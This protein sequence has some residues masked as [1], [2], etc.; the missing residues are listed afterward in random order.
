MFAFHA[1]N[2]YPSVSRTFSRAAGMIVGTVA[3]GHVAT[4]AYDKL[5]KPIVDWQFPRSPR[6]T[7]APG[8]LIR[9][10]VSGSRSPCRITL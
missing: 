6:R 4:N 2:Y 9:V 1:A 10:F 8:P 3:P 7:P 5:V